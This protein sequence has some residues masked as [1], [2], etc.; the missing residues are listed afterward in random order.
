MDKGGNLERGSRSGRSAAAA[1]PVASRKAR[2]LFV[3]PHPIQPSMAL[4]A[5]SAIAACT[6]AELHVLS[7]LPRAGAIRGRADE[8]LNLREARHHIAECVAICRQTRAWFEETLGEPLALERL[9]IRCGH[10]AEAIVARAVDIDARV[11]VLG[12]MARAL[13][14]LAMGLAHASGRPVLV[15]RGHLS[16]GTILAATD[17][18]DGHYPVVRQASALGVA[19]GAPVVAVHNV[20]CLSTPLGACLDAGARP[21]PELPRRVMADLPASPELVVTTEIDSA[22]AILEQAQR[23]RAALIVVGAR[24][25]S[26]RH[27]QRS[28]S[29]AVI[30]RSPC[31]VL[32]MSLESTGRRPM[33]RERSQVSPEGARAL[34]RRNS[35]L[36]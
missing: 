12:P 15:A 3:L 7:V 24:K 18:L 2:L 22:G 16:E 32:V 1:L 6:R 19:L 13:G 10:L 23:H 14:P 34:G 35:G 30:A 36:A 8:P 25:R 9:R 28:I 29:S 5:A 17:L 20:T 33:F 11:I 26:A 4:K 31:S 21:I 27:P